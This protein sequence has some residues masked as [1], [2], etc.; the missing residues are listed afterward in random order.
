MAAP[1]A[2]RIIDLLYPLYGEMF[3]APG[4]RARAWLPGLTGQPGYGA[5]RH[6]AEADNAGGAAKALGR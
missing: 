6:L 4:H 2:G 1:G 3:Y 5:L